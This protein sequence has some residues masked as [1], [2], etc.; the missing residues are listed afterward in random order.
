VSNAGI[1]PNGGFACDWQPDAGYPMVPAGTTALWVN[2]VD[3]H[4]RLLKLGTGDFYNVK[5]QSLGNGSFHLTNFG[6]APHIV[7]G[8]WLVARRDVPIALKVHLDNSTHCTVKNVTMF[9]NGFAPIFETGGSG[10]HILGCCWLPGPRPAG[11]MEDP[12]VTNAADGFHS[13]GT[14]VG[15]DIENC[16]MKGV[17]LDDC[18]AIHGEFSDVVS[19]NGAEVVVKG[20]AS[21]TVGQPIVVCDQKGHFQEAKLTAV[22]PTGPQIFTVTTA[23]TLTIGPSSKAYNPEACGAG[24]KIIACRLGDTRSRGILAKANDGLIERN[25]IE[26]CGMSAVSLGPEYYWGEGGYVSRVLVDRNLFDQNG[27][28]GYGGATVL[29]H[30]EGAPG[31]RFITIRANLFK[32]SYQGDIDLEWT[33]H[34]LISRN[35][36]FGRTAWPAFMVRQSTIQV[37]NSA[38]ISLNRNEVRNVAG[39]KQPIL[40]VGPNASIEANDDGLIPLGK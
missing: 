37:T 1:D 18:F 9:Y 6:K 39:Y 30:G 5:W 4:T 20:N 17:F 8:D 21:W 16:L 12:L 13:V 10:N 35:A 19:T 23:P 7:N 32:S 27:T 33:Q 11:A 34:A 15:P 25:L 36:F 38:F 28:A 22:A 29:V 14:K 24:Y 2:V 31:N 40:A 26:R 3:A